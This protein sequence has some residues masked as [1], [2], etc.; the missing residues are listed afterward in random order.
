MYLT[1]SFLRAV[2]G[3]WKGHKLKIKRKLD[4]IAITKNILYA[5]IVF[6]QIT[7]DAPPVC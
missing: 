2:K 1:R 4:Y 7:D 5:V 3:C 6:V